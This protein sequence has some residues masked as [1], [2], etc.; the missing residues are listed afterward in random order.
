MTVDHERA[1]LLEW[2][3]EAARTCASPAELASAVCALPGVESAAVRDRLV[4]TAPPM[5][6]VAIQ[7]GPRWVVVDVVLDPGGGLRIGDLHDED[8]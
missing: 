7:L 8:R 1:A 6:E 2:L 5:Q 3:E 4:K